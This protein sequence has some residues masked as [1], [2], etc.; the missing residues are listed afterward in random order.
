MYPQP[1]NP[2]PHAAT[3]VAAHFQYLSTLTCTQLHSNRLH[4]HFGNFLVTFTAS[5]RQ[6]D[7]QL[8]ITTLHINAWCP[9]TKNS[10]LLISHYL[11]VLP[12]YLLYRKLI[13]CTMCILPCSCGWACSKVVARSSSDRWVEE[14]HFF[15]R[16]SLLSFSS[17]NTLYWL[18]TLCIT[19][20]FLWCVSVLGNN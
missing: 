16:D 7:C 4:H 19:S 11:C 6:L 9:Y 13:C 18:Y 10:F 1:N 15:T 12:A 8:P 5:S 3:S 20:P 14:I 2:H 17:T